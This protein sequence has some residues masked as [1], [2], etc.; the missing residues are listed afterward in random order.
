MIRSIVPGCLILLAGLLLAGCGS[1][2]KTEGDSSKAVDD[3]S[4]KAVAAKGDSSNK[5]S[6][7]KTADPKD[8]NTTKSNTGDNQPGEPEATGDGV[9]KVDARTLLSEYTNDQE[10][11]DRKY[12]GKVLQV[13]G[14]VKYWGDL[15]GVGLEGGKDIPA[16]VQCGFPSD[17]MKAIREH[18]YVMRSQNGQEIK[19]KATIV[20]QGKCNG[21]SKGPV[22]LGL[23]AVR[24]NDCKVIDPVLLKR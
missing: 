22:V 15:S 20:I 10:T 8:G 14:V 13:K 11:A 16:L 17:D 6:A 1:N 18:N 21:I 19:E 3:S 12:K 4:K 23:R 9:V 2:A 24:L 5:A 7:S